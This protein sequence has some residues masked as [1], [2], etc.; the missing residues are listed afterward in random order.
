MIISPYRTQLTRMIQNG[1]SNPSR[2][3]VNRKTLEK[4]QRYSL[5][6]IRESKKLAKG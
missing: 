4:S 1:E 2:S 3:D 6:L 5:W